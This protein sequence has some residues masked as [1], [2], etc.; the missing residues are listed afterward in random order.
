MTSHNLTLTLNLSINS[1][2][3]LKLFTSTILAHKSLAVG[4]NHPKSSTRPQR[5]PLR[6]PQRNLHKA[7][8]KLH[9]PKLHRGRAMSS[10]VAAIGEALTTET[11]HK[12]GSGRRACVRRAMLFVFRCLLLL[13][14]ER[15]AG[16]RGA[17]KRGRYG[18]RYPRR[19][20]GPTPPVMATVGTRFSAG[21]MCAML[22]SPL[23]SFLYLAPCFS[24]RGIG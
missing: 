21:S 19:C 14:G 16:A 9:N 8:K 7:Q 6:T 12:F 4:E 15:G 17:Y 10:P 22:P 13:E 2:K 23:V 18:D 20:P 11:K 1:Y 5:G 3:T 24:S